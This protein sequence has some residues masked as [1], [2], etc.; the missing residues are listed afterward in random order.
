[1]YGWVS[2]ILVA[3]L[4]SYLTGVLSE[5]VPPPKDLLCKISLGFC[6]PPAVIVFGATDIDRI[7]DRDGVGQGPGENQI[8]ML[9]NR[10]D[11]NVE[12]PNMVK[13]K[14]TSAS[15]GAFKLRV[16]YASPNERPVEITAR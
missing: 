7:I 16:L 4:A 1:M 14:L 2:G 12:R 3:F 9:H 15:S 11:P 13:Y 5:L 10:V 8:G 6:P